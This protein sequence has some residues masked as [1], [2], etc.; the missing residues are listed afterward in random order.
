MLFLMLPEYSGFHHQ[1][2]RL[3]SPRIICQDKIKHVKIFIGENACEKKKMGS[4]LEK[5]GKTIQIQC[6][7]DPEG[8]R[9]GRKIRRKQPGLLCCRRKVQKYSGAV[10]E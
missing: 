7:S 2:V 8:R 1:C 9:M 4:M 6:K 5:A 10:L 3:N